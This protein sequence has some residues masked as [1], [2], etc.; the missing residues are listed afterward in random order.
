MGRDE[1]GL[2]EDLSSLDVKSETETIRA[3]SPESSRGDSNS[4]CGSSFNGLLRHEHPL[5]RPEINENERK[6]KC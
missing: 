5:D 4:K 2:R 1:D 3:E 6:S